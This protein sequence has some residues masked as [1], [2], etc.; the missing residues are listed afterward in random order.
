M[1]DA[2]PVPRPQRRILKYALVTLCAL[3]L[4]AGAAI[5]YLVA[6]FDPRDYHDRIVE[7]VRE[8][9]GRTLE[10]QGEI[11][12]S[13]W[14]DAGVRLGKLTLS[15]REGTERFVTIDS[16]R[17]RLELVPLLSGELVAAELAIT[18]ANIR[19]IRYEDGRLNVDDLFKGEGAAPRFDIGKVVVERSTLVYSDLGTGVRYDLSEVTVET[20][21]LANTITTPLTL[22]FVAVDAADTFRVGARLRGRLELDLEGQRYGFKQASLGL[23]GRVAGVPDLVASASG[24]AAVHM[25]GNEAQISTL[26]ASL[27]GTHGPDAM[28]MTID[29][30]RLVLVPGA[31]SGDAVLLGLTAKGPAGTTEAK[32]AVPSVRRVGDKIE[33]QA[34]ALDLALVRGEHT[35]RAAVSTPLGAAIAAREVALRR[36]DASFTVLGPRLPR[37]GVAG[38]MKGDA[39]VEAAKEGVHLRL[40]GKVGESKVKAQLT[41]AGFAAPV[42]TFAVDIDE[43]DLDRYAAS[44]TSGRAK[45]PKPPGNPGESLLAPFADLPATGTLTVGVLKSANLKA[46]NV[47]LVVK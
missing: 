17:L 20:G 9:T 37:A 28:A 23:Q 7:L 44:D 2:V 36:I 12:L 21:R 35:L 33:A 18:G 27:T 32:L 22:A 41:T 30:A 42:Y 10:I 43:L 1:P 39:R 5:A 14:P 6:S 31:A 13:F 24:D 40:A 8:K 46:G 19:I 45:A 4:L 16:A 26:S 25:K 47:R 11:G 29:A 3:V 15:E 38:S 34:A